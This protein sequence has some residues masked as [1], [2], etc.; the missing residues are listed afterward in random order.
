MVSPDANF[1][2]VPL[3]CNNRACTKPA[4]EEHRGSLHLKNH[5]SQIRFLKK[6]VFSPK[7]WIFTGWVVSG[8]IDEIRAKGRAE[9]IR[10]STLLQRHSKTP[11]VIY[12]EYKIKDDGSYYLHFHAVG[13]S[14]GDIHLVQALWGRVV[15]YEKPITTNDALISYI[16][17]YTGKTP[18]FSDAQV[19]ENYLQLV[20]KAQMCRYSVPRKDAI[21]EFPFAES[22]GFYLTSILVSEMY[23]ALEQGRHHLRE[24]GTR[25]DFI[26]YLDRPPDPNSDI[27]SCTYVYS[28]PKRVLPRAQK[29][30][31]V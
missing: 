11:F 9:L 24:D 12:M 29:T 1:V 2:Q 7:A 6:Y 30:L 26:P 21:K 15:R 19:S 28:K 23:R 20:Y 17:K 25:K 8:P 4:C 10:L 22:S 18:F 31:A 14:F 16:K 27:P 3:T 13:G 5:E